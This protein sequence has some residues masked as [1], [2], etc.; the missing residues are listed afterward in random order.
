MPYLPG[1]PDLADVVGQAQ[2]RYALDVRRRICGEMSGV[3]A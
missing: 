1:M 3:S 2:A